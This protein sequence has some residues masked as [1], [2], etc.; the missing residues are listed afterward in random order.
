MLKNIIFFIVSVFSCYGCSSLNYGKPYGQILF[1]EGGKTDSISSYVQ[2][3]NDYA[4]TV[5]HSDVNGAVAYNSN[6]YDVR[7]LKIHSNKVPMWGNANKGDYLSMSG[8]PRKQQ[9]QPTIREGN[10]IGKITAHNK[11]D[12]RAV[13]TLIVKGMSG[14]PVF[15]VNNEVVGINI[16]YSL[17]KVNINGKLTNISIYLPYNVIQSEWLKFK[18]QTF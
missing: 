14:G 2:W 4:V 17:D 7:F 18:N 10:D 11:N 3:N 9:K 15:N 13:N 16:G 6:E 5:K 1:K 12:Y 8:Y